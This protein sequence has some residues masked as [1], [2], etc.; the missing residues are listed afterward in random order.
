MSQDRRHLS[1]WRRG[2]GTVKYRPEKLWEIQKV[3]R[4]LNRKQKTTA[5]TSMGVIETKTKVREVK[6][7]VQAAN[8][9]GWDVSRKIYKPESCR[10][11]SPILRETA[12][13]KR[14]SCAHPLII[15]SKN[16]MGK[17]STGTGCTCPP[18]NLPMMFL[19]RGFGLR[20][21]RA[22]RSA[23]RLDDVTLD[24]S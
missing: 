2:Q 19:S 5:I 12:E 7:V 16:E 1:C 10:D 24:L 4:N 11:L 15:T 3:V 20:P 23:L 6:R 13:Q 18:R 22:L 21:F 8:A 17:R 9:R 14:G